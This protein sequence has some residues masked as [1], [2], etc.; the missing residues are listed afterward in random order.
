MKKDIPV[1][2]R[3]TFKSFEEYKEWC[4]EK[5]KKQLEQAFEKINLNDNQNR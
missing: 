2:F 4:I 3:N 1:Q 5:S